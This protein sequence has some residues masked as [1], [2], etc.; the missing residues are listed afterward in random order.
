LNRYVYVS[1]M[2]TMLVDPLGMQ[3]H[4]QFFP[5]P[6]PCA[7]PSGCAQWGNDAFDAMVGAPG[8]YFNLDNGSV[9]WGFSITKWFSDWAAI[10]AARAANDWRQTPEVEAACRQKV[11]DAINAIYSVNPTSQLPEGVVSAFFFN[12]AWNFNFTVGPATKIRQERKTL[13]S[14]GVAAATLHVPSSYFW[15]PQHVWIQTSSSLTFTAHLDSANGNGFPIGT[16]L[17]FIKDVLGS[18]SRQP[19]PS[20]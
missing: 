7:D 4:P 2:P 14:A 10:D 11:I 13:T 12:G 3:E 20:N 5:A 8:T 19:C 9:N 17:H 15:D 6:N 18:D 16:V 1:D